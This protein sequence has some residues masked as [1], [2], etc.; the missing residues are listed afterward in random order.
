MSKAREISKCPRCNGAAHAFAQGRSWAVACDDRKCGISTSGHTNPDKAIEAWNYIAGGKSLQDE[1][2][3]LQVDNDRIS[4][5]FVALET[6]YEVATSD[7]DALLDALIELRDDTPPASSSL[8]KKIEAVIT[9]V[10]QHQTRRLG[11]W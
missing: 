11:S 1:R 10:E 3:A 9:S 7:R 5:N 8:R 2:D 6:K 4:N